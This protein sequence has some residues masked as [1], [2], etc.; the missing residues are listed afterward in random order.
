M[1][2]LKVARSKIEELEKSVESYTKEVSVSHVQDT[3]SSM[4]GDVSC[5][6][7]SMCICFLR[8]AVGADKAEKR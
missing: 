4:V 5:N 7:S 3:F 2:E 1:A 8:F 6:I